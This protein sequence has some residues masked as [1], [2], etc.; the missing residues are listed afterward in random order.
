M[1]VNVF[2]AGFSKC[3]T[4]TL[5]HLLGRHPGIFVPA[6]KETWYFVADDYDDRLAGIERFYSGSRPGQLL[7]DGTP[8]YSSC[9]AEELALARI[10]DSCPQA[11]FIFIARDPRQRI[12]SSYRELHHS[13][14]LWGFDTP[15]DLGEAMLIQPQM[16]MDSLYWT[17]ISRYRETFGD[18]RI[19]VV[20]L[21]DLVARRGR[22]LR[23]CFDFLGLEAHAVSDA[24]PIALNT[25]SSKRM[26]TR[27]LRR[28][29]N[30]RFIGPRL[31]RIPA[32]VQDRL[33]VPLGLRRRSRATIYW[34]PEAE[35]VLS[36]TVA[37]DAR[38]FLEFYG[39]A[40]DFW[41]SVAGK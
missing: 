23:R 17:R 27:L 14:P 12:E 7:L 21:E 3:G 38:R 19:L 2:V 11:R 37:P 29:R 1:Q 25:G 33:L 6:E 13:S 24:E 36:E 40:V 15:F 4:T 22:E 9:G 31:A 20:F 18:T 8:E 41:P 5:C 28:L 35:R 30:N 26:D 32:A 39:K 10:L 16:V 34:S